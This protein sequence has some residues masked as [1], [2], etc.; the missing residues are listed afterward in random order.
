MRAAQSLPKPS[1]VPSQVTRTLFRSAKK[2]G[3]PHVR[4]CSSWCSHSPE[5]GRALLLHGS[6]LLGGGPGELSDERRWSHSWGAFFSAPPPPLCHLLGVCAV[7][8]CFFLKC[9]RK[10]RGD[11]GKRGAARTYA[12]WMFR[13]R[14]MCCVRA[15]VCFLD[16]LSPSSPPP[17][18]LRRAL[19]RMTSAPPASS[20]ASF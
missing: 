6:P 11:G 13:P 7:L 20:C 16:V 9:V 15:C 1:V 5:R 12:A 8:F 17:P 3:A 14:W 18:P 4:W 19:C 2:G 10:E